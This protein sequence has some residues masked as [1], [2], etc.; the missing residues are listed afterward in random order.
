[1]FLRCY[2]RPSLQ[3]DVDGNVSIQVGGQV[4]VGMPDGAR[5]VETG[6]WLMLSPGVEHDVEAPEATK[7]RLTIGVADD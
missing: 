6:E 4:E 7:M 1:M 3:G 2:L 5:P